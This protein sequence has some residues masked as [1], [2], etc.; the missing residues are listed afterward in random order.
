[1][2]SKPTLSV[3]AGNLFLFEN[4]SNKLSWSKPHWCRWSN[5]WSTFTGMGISTGLETDFWRK[6]NGS[7]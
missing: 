6:Q 4:C 5:S 7:G 1:M 3:L 2:Q